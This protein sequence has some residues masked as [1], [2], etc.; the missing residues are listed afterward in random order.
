MQRDVLRRATTGDRGGR[1]TDLDRQP[2]PPGTLPRLGAAQQLTSDHAS[3]A[4]S[5]SA[6]ARHRLRTLTNSRPGRP[7]TVAGVTVTAIGSGTGATLQP[8]NPTNVSDLAGSPVVPIPECEAD[9]QGD[10]H[11]HDEADPAPVADHDRAEQ[12]QRDGG[13]PEPWSSSERGEVRT[14]CPP[15][16]GLAP[17]SACPRSVAT[18][19]EGAADHDEDSCVGRRP[20]GRQPTHG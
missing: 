14:W 10:G 8:L 4:S 11:G 6:S 2:L 7:G 17:H 18:H 9:R 20:L 12:D 16:A 13:E 15:I 1:R 3:S 5:N 19:P